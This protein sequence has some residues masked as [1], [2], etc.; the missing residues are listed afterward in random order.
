MIR[1]VKLHFKKEKLSDF[2]AHFEMVKKKIN[3]FPGC[4]G[5]KLLQDKKSE[6]IVFTYSEW[7]TEQDLENYR[8]SALFQSIWP[9]I[10]A[11][12]DQR[13]EAWSTEP[14]FDGFDTIS[15]NGEK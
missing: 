13:A 9:V 10:K 3:A 4:K 6:N 1:I 14:F 8:Q 5:M 11:W 2:I 7:E 12:F 15:T